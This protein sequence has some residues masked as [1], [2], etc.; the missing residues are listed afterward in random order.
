MSK[1]PLQ[2][3]PS[4]QEFKAENKKE[5]LAACADKFGHHVHEW[6]DHMEHLY[7]KHVEKIRKNTRR[8]DRD[9]FSLH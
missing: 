7:D 6:E 8:A 3:I 5:L 2:N 9:E 1:I 4:Y